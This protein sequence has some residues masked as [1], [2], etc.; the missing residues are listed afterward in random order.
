MRRVPGAFLTL[1]LLLGA[2][3][4]CSGSDE[5]ISAPEVFYVNP[6]G[7][8]SGPKEVATYRLSVK[9][10]APAGTGKTHRLTVD[11]P[12]G[13]QDAIRLRAGNVDCKGSTTHVTC[14][15]ASRSIDWDGSQQIVPVAAKGSSVGD[16]G[17]VHL[18]YVREDGKKLTARTRV[19]VGSPIVQL[20][21]LT[22]KD[23]QPGSDVTAPVV[24]RN[25][26]EMP[27]KGLGLLFD[28]GSLEFRERYSNCRYP[29]LMSTRSAVCRFPDVRIDPGEAVV[30]R[31]A[32]R[33]RASKTEMYDTF[34]RGAWA[35][36]AGTG[37]HSVAFEGGD[38]GDGPALEAFPAQPTDLKG[39]TWAEGNNISSAVHLDTHADFEV[40]GAD[41]HGSPGTKRTLRL[42]VRN[43][44]PGNPGRSTQLVF[45]P[46]LDVGVLKQPMDEY[47]DGAYEPYCKSNGFA[48]TCDVGE[49]AP[50]K[51][52]TF[53]FTLRLGEPGE[54]SATLQDTE[55]ATK[56]GTVSR[57]PNPLNDTA[58]VTVGP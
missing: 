51:S 33:L 35:L 49:L 24:V 30:I 20:R 16:V 57:D 28:R 12:R 6:Y 29:T 56:L 54:G 7:A 22:F 19:V 5:S 34:Y 14:D 53:E 13:S 27:V 40:S 26:G 11:V 25:V 37:P 21:T 47:D 4:A 2:L 10:G 46:P 58:S 18:T 3:V 52:R 32:V 55:Q 41:L 15:V 17:Y 44:G 9:G 36:D 50:G 39:G 43:D 45:S 1:A 23:V 42:T 48:Y 31:P 38:S 8:K